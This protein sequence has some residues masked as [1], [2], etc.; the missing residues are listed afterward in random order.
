MTRWRIRF[1]GEDAPREFDNGDTGYTL[2]TAFHALDRAVTLAAV[3][4]A[5][6]GLRN[7]PVI[8]SVQFV[9]DNG[10]PCK[11]PDCVGCK[12]F[13]EEAPKMLQRRFDEVADSLRE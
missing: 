6:E 13:S 4:A 5:F 11:D 3:D 2:A 7:P 10:K 1:A 12:G 8:E 9:F